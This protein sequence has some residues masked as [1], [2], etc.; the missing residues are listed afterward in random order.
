MIISRQN[1]ATTA[2][3]PQIFHFHYFT[4]NLFFYFEVCGIDTLFFIF[5]FFFF[6]LFVTQIIHDFD[7]QKV[8]PKIMFIQFVA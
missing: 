2:V 5:F 1:T 3:T 6:N 4:H 7:W 8:V